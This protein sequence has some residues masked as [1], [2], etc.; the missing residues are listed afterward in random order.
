[1]ATSSAALNWA[2][3]KHRINVHPVYVP[4]P[5][6]HVVL[7]LFVWTSLKLLKQLYTT[8]L[9]LLCILCTKSLKWT[10]TGHTVHQSNCPQY[11]IWK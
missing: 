2:P 11:H 1:M 6:E 7:N 5:T 10:E 3:V 8:F 4:C 9:P